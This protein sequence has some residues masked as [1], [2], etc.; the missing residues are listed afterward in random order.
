MDSL[1]ESVPVPAIITLSGIKKSSTANP[2]LKNSGFETTAKSTEAF[3]IIFLSTF[4]AV[5]TGTVDLLMII[6]NEVIIS[7]N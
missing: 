4:S 5:P 2:S 6:L 1:I 3:S 7:L